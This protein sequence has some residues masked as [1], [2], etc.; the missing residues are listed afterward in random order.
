M[1]ICGTNLTDSEVLTSHFV[2]I[3]INEI[4]HIASKIVKER[5]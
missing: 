2:T 5:F 4:M 1:L 3:N